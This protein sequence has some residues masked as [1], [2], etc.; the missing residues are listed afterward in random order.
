MKKSALLIVLGTLL[1]ATG[2]DS[3]RI[4]KLEKQNR[5]LARAF[6]SSISLQALT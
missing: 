3:E 2:C 1:M 5:E 4:A 6:K